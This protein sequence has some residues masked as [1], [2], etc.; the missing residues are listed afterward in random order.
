[1]AGSRNGRCLARMARVVYGPFKRPA[2]PA[3]PW[4]HLADDRAFRRWTADSDRSLKTDDCR[5]S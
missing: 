3:D 1:V 2:T 5:L 4:A